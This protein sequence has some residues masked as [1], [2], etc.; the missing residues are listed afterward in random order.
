MRCRKPSWT[1][2]RRRAVLVGCD[3]LVIFELGPV[4]KDD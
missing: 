3:W 4:I 1:S 2:I